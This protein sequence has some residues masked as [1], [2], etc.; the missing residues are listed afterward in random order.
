MHAERHRQR[1]RVYIGLFWLSKSGFNATEDHHN[2]RFFKRSLE[3]RAEPASAT[4]RPELNEVGCNLHGITDALPVPLL[5]RPT[6]H[7]VVDK[8]CG[9][10]HGCVLHGQ[11]IVQV[12]VG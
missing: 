5:A 2:N 7:G 11:L 10:G 1:I 3:L 6:D 8:A 4:L 9:P 12:H